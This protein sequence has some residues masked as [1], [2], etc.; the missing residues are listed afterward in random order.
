MDRRAN[1]H[2][3]VAARR[4][5][6]AVALIAFV[7][8]GAVAQARPRPSVSSAKADPSIVAAMAGPDSRTVSV[9]VRET[10]PASRAAE[11]LV[12]AQGGRITHQLSIVGGFSARIPARGLDAL[13]ASPA[14]ARISG[15]GRLRMNGVDMRQ[16][17]VAAANVV[18]RQVVRI[19]QANVIATGAGVGVAI[20][21]TGVSDIPDLGSR[22]IE[23]VDFTPDRDGIDHY[24]HGTHLAGIIASDGTSNVNY[25]GVAPK[26]NIISVK[27]AGWNGATDVSVVLAGLQWVVSNRAA[28]NIRVLNLSFGTDSTQSYLM[29]P[30][31]YAVERAWR[32]GIFVVVSAGNRGPNPGTINK[33]G[34]D[35]YVMTVGAAD[36]KNTLS[37][38]DD[39]VAEFSSRGPTQDGIAKPDLV[40]PGISIVSDLAPNSYVSS[41]HPAAVISDSYIKG[42]G[43]SQAAAVVSGVAAL[44]FQTDPALTPNVAKATLTGT[45]AR[46]M[47]SLAG[48]GAGLVDAGGAVNNVILKTYYNAPANQNLSRS[49]GL[50]SL[51]ASRGSVHIYADLNRD[52]TPELV[53]GEVD[54]LGKAWDATSWS[55]TSWSATSWSATSWAAT[56]WSATSWS[57]T[58]WSATSWSGMGW[59]ATS[60]SATSWSATSWSATSWSATSWSATSWSSDA[61]S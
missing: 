43:T 4:W 9:I 16:Y 18:W 55:A 7:L 11:D 58:S 20:I 57:A 48:V 27:V 51:E 12:R 49:S 33:P 21:D 22:V 19:P 1:R 54:V 44:M 25:P 15:D 45:A 2:N 14:I 50:G 37:K 41:T 23:R 6:V 56:S 32:S 59:D 13:V 5:P 3:A 28:Y 24:G 35:P 47:A 61:W 36:V 29:D 8:S 53:S 52:G 39:V 42:T 30:L 31:D 10:R 34:D 17:D 40:A 38:A 46:N 60:W 26:A